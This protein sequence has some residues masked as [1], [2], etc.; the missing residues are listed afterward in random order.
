MRE[1][2]KCNDDAMKQSK[3]A[4]QQHAEKFD[5]AAEW[6]SM[7]MSKQTVKFDGAGRK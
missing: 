6:N 3:D 1:K 5:S 4:G 2:N 7:S